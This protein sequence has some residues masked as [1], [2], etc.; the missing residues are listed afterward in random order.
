MEIKLENNY[1]IER[2]GG[3][4]DFVPCS[5]DREN[6]KLFVKIV[7]GECQ[8]AHIALCLSAVESHTGLSEIP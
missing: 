2:N 6:D 8:G 3:V 1:R 5:I 4:M 7:A